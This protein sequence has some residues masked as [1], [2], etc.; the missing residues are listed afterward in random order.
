M[1]RVNLK[2]LSEEE[3]RLEWVT[4]L[5]IANGGGGWRIWVP[6][7]EDGGFWTRERVGRQGGQRSAERW[8]GRSTVGRDAAGEVGTG[9]T[10][11]EKWGIKKFEF[12]F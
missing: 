1:P 4:G 6:G 7:V 10:E 2:N 11:R 8:L 5:K 12:D 3:W 9:E